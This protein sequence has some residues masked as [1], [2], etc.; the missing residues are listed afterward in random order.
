MDYFFSQDDYRRMADCI[1]VSWRE[2]VFRQCVRPIVVEWQGAQSLYDL[3]PQFLDLRLARRTRGPPDPG[4]SR[5][6]QG[7]CLAGYD[8]VESPEVQ[9]E[10]KRP[11]D[12]VIA[13]VPGNPLLAM[14]SPGQ[15]FAPFGHSLGVDGD[16]P[17]VPDRHVD[18]SRADRSISEDV[19][20][21]GSRLCPPG[22][23]VQCLIEDAEA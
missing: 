4:E 20:F 23:R 5:R 17:A 1:V 19:F 16:Q 6:R 18:G 21:H 10:G 12:V 9:V 11:L 3:P 13:S 8:D 14:G 15:I 2:P 7:A 22:L